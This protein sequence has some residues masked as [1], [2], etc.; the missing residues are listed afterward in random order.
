MLK[1]TKQL[2]KYNILGTVTSID[3]SPLPGV[4]VFIEDSYTGVNT[5]FNGSFT[6]NV[7]SG[8]TLVFS[9]LGMK[10]QKIKIEE[11]Q[12]LNIKLIQVG[13][14]LEEV[15]IVGYGFKKKENLSGAVASVDKE[16]FESRGVA[17]TGQALQGAIANLNVISSGSPNSIPDFNIRG[18][19]SIEADGSV[20]SASPLFIIDGISA[21][22]E[23]FGRM[24]ANDIASISVLKDAVSASIYGSRA[25]FGVILVTTKKGNSDVMRINIGANTRIQTLGRTPEFELNPYKTLSFQNAMAK[26]WYN[27]FNPEQL[28]YA[29]QV[30][31]GNAEPTRISPTNANAYWTCNKKSDKFSKTYATFLI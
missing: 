13:T 7:S 22:S 30:S 9:Y 20:T 17:T 27:L 6:I 26:P 8:R 21:T 11:E 2:L 24:N 16:V 28:E 31:L 4:N 18:V 14:E 12:P 23:D 5:D 3:G 25:S 1:K 10:T 19:T 15:I 29:R